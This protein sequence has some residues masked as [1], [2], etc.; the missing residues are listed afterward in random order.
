MYKQL[1]QY[2]LFNQI[3][4]FKCRTRSKSVNLLTR[5]R[6]LLC[7]LCC[8]NFCCLQPSNMKDDLKLLVGF[9]CNGL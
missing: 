9:G 4:Y 7:V 2:F 6:P 3:I 5:G 1:F 8:F